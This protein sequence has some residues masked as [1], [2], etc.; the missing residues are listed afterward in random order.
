MEPEKRAPLHRQRTK[1]STSQPQST[2]QV[3][4]AV[5]VE[6]RR[7]GHSFDVHHN[8]NHNHHKR[9]DHASSFT[10]ECSHNTRLTSC[11]FIS[12]ESATR[13]LRSWTL[14]STA[15]SLYEFVSLD[16]RLLFCWWLSLHIQWFLS[17]LSKV[18]CYRKRIWFSRLSLR[19]GIYLKILLQ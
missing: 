5:P 16:Y 15:V 17:I 12:V 11:S 14:Q 18:H 8:H 4:Q 6:M 9:K 19:E 3:R 10:S 2:S 1:S 13:R 7:R